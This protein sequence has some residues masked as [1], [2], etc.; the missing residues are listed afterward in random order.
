M[1]AAVA[2]ASIPVA[3]MHARMKVADACRL[4]LIILRLVLSGS[5]CSEPVSI[6]RVEPLSRVSDASP[7]ARSALEPSSHVFPLLPLVPLGVSDVLV[8]GARRSDATAVP[9]RAL[10]TTQAP[11]VLTRI[12]VPRK[13]ASVAVATAFAAPAPRASRPTS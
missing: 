10:E 5:S 7:H 2:A 4:S 11:Q 1:W 6:S 13:S 8:R 3:P 9:V 12:A